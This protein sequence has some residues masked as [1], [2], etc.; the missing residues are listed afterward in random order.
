MLLGL[1]GIQLFLGNYID[2]LIQGHYLE[3]SPWVVLASVI[4]WGWVWGIPG[5]LLGVPITVAIMLATAQ[6]S[7]T[8]A[9]A[10]LISRDADQLVP[11]RRPAVAA[12]AS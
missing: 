9:F 7:S 4:V 11:D 2:P 6:F 10:R 3:M 12:R 5:A 8:E 1:G